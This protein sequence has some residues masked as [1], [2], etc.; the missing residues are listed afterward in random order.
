MAETVGRVDFLVDLDGR[1]MPRDARALGE[2]AG[3]EGAKSFGDKFDNTLS[4][5]MRQVAEG[6]S[7]RLNNGVR[8]NDGVL[9]RNSLAI[10]TFGRDG[11]TAFDR[12]ANRA[13]A[14]GVQAED[15]FRKF[16]RSGGDA[17]DRVSER[18]SAFSVGARSSLSKF[19]RALETDQTRLDRFN[20]QWRDLSHNTRQWSLII[21]AVAAGMQSLAGLSSA[22]G[23]GLLAVGGA[24][25]AAVLGGGAMVAVFST[26]LK[27]IGDLPPE[28][29]GVATQFRALGDDLVDVRDTISSAAF[30][31]MPNTFSRLSDSVRE[32]SPQFSRLG[33]AAGRVFDDFSKGLEVGSDGF[34]ELSDLIDNAADDFPALAKAAGTWSV[35]LMRG[36]NEA[37]PMVDQL[38]GYI[39]E[40]GD[41]F[42]AFTKSDSF[43]Q[44]V[45]NSMETFSRFGELLD[46]TGRALNDL[47]TPESIVRLQAFLGN[48]T[49]FMPNL[50]RL[51]DILGRLDVF[52]LAAQLLNDFGRALEPLA[53]PIAEM[54]DAL[55]DVASILIE[56]LADALGIVADLV[57][58]LAQGLANVIDSI[59]PNLLNAAATGVIAL[60]GAFALLK[61]AQGIAG[62]ASSM[63]LFAGAATTAGTG[64]GKLASGLKGLVGKAGLIG[65]GVIGVSALFEGLQELTREMSGIDD[66]TR[67]LVATNATFAKSFETVADKMSGVGLNPYIGESLDGIANM[68]EALTRL[69]DNDFSLMLLDDFQE[70]AA[71]AGRLK[72]VLDELDEPLATLASTDLSAAS[73]QFAAWAEELGA[74]D[75]QV[76]NMINR[77]PQFKEQLEAAALAQGGVASQAD[78]VS[79]ALTGVTGN[80]NVVGGALA[81]AA[82]SVLGTKD[83]LVGLGD[84][85]INTGL[86]VDA[87]SQKIL[88]FGSAEL[89]TREASRSFKEAIDQLSEGIIANGATLD[90]NTAQGRLNE[91]NLDNLATSTL[92]FASATVKQTG[93]QGAANAVIAKGRE[94]LIEQLGAFGITGDAADNYA[95]KLGLI[96]D[97][98]ATDLVLNGLSAAEN[99]LNWA[100]RDRSARI[101]VWT[102]GTGFSIG[103]SDV[104][105][106]ARGGSVFGPTQALIGEAG[107]EAVVPLDRPLSQVDSSV[108]WLSAIAQGKGRMAM[109]GGGV[110]GGGNSV[111][112]EAGAIVV[113]GAVDPRQ[114]AYEVADLIAERIAS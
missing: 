20:L 110:A 47:V 16:G 4:P 40:L 12:I 113:Q 81:N 5:R 23:A 51:L 25:S 34:E 76:L 41:R 97:D 64:A 57:A 54:A 109:A 92:A 63:G 45:R 3:A 52:G 27:D 14:F 61:G 105:P 60:A 114:T 102:D 72:V 55:N 90:T 70:G 79:L 19:W 103:N 82:V 99:A 50:S 38:I 7:K 77:M 95:N 85:A 31:E 71:G 58:P 101:T 9:R 6:M 74:S 10:R 32:L 108:R 88:N 13:F 62:L 87:L 65:L 75:Q 2:K 107:P 111:T 100:A 18:A 96:P 29:R 104:T 56:R 11:E 28:L 22:L 98:V 59:P 69:G 21:G 83:G 26:L 17:F 39:Q 78:L 112:I 48:L 68:D 33:T 42:D 89:T 73:G 8:L 80:V 91:V 106:F 53:G 43:G 1:N 93:D 66:A 36:I 94:R 44:W 37:N 24:L 86:D 15:S 84:E 35:A 49:D 30:A 67:E 46:A